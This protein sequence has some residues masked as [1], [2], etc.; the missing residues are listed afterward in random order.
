MPQLL[1]PGAV[2]GGTRPFARRI[3]GQDLALGV[4]M[5][6]AAAL[7]IGLFVALGGWKLSHGMH[8]TVRFDDATGLV[9][10]SPVVVAGVPVGRV[11]R[12]TLKD[13]KAV[14]LLD[15]ERSADLRVDM[16]AGIR[17]KSLLGEKIVELVPGE[18]SAPRLADGAVLTRS[19]SAVEPDQILAKLGPVLANVDPEDLA[20]LVR[21]GA[22]A[23]DSKGFARLLDLAD[24]LDR[25]VTAGG[26][27]LLSAV[28]GLNRA[29]PK[30]ESV[31]NHLVA[32]GPAIERVTAQADKLAA[33]APSLLDR[34][35]LVLA[36]TDRL[37]LSMDRGPHLV[38]QADAV[39]SRMPA[40]LDRL[41]RM[42]DRLGVT[43]EKAQPALEQA[44]ALLNEATIRRLLREEGV[45]VRFGPF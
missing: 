45:R 30:A 11:E 10:D 3:E 2:G 14:A 37:L 15:L 41:D 31:L 5:L 1:D 43:L 16:L 13:G 44:S 40:T 32:A 12:L 38:S 6:A 33:R 39:F 35:D 8:V 34:A 26:P 18:P 36:R 17:S 23:V 20:T 22:K 21:A 28:K 9:K 29:I 25:A 19:R 4:F 27:D 42:T 24:R 7:L